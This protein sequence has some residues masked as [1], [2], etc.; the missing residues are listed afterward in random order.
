LLRRVTKSALP[1]E[2]PNTKEGARERFR[3]GL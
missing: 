3:S 1:K 2:L